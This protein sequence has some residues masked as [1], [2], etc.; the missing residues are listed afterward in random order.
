M[1][2]GKYLKN[3]QFLEYA[4]DTEVGETFYDHTRFQM[5]SDEYD[6]HTLVGLH[7]IVDKGVF[8]RFGILIVKTNRNGKL[9]IYYI[10]L[11]MTTIFDGIYLHLSDLAFPRYLEDV[12][13]IDITNP[14]ENKFLIWSTSI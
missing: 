9:E 13:H 10:M 1:K 7:E 5:V 4:R 11:R 2:V 14:Y 3:I 8:S 6:D 12:L